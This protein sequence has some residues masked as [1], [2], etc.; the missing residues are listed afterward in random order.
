MRRAVI[1]SVV[2]LLAGGWF[3]PA[4]SQ[5]AKAAP[6]RALFETRCAACHGLD[7]RGGE[8]LG[9]GRGSAAAS[10]TDARLRTILH[11]GLPRGMPAFGSLLAD[12]DLNAVLQ[13]LRDLQ[14]ATAANG[15]A[16]AVSG[17]AEKGRALFFGKAACAQCHMARGQGGFLASDLTGLRLD[18]G[19]IR[20]AIVS[21]SVSAKTVRT[22]LT[23]LAGRKI[24][25]IT[26]NEDNFSIQLQ[27]E[28]GAFH[29]ID[30]AMVADTVRETQPLMPADYGRRLSAAELQDLVSYLAGMSTPAAPRH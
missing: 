24:T 11:D 12:A 3:S 18:A 8:A 16:D 25:G 27:D 21:P 23:L 5:P 2:I 4:A 15:T 20:R 14:R 9:I 1:S 22:T 29:L 7:A 28:Q 17:D 26:R 13:Y 6:G 19:E 10:Y 30:K